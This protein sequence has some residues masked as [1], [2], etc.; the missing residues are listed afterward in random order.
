M[1]GQYGDHTN[2]EVDESRSARA[3]EKSTNG[4]KQPQN[5]VSKQ[6]H[7]PP[8]IFTNWC[9]DFTSLKGVTT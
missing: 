8:I 1:R 2:L 4:K 9:M 6:V 5:S 7:T 3:T